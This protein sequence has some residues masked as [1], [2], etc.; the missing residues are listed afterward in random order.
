MGRYASHC[1]SPAL[2]L[3]PPNTL[4]GTH[5][6]RKTKGK[7]KKCNIER[8]WLEQASRTRLPLPAKP[9]ALSL[10]SHCCGALPTLVYI[11][12]LRPESGRGHGGVGCT[13][14]RM[15]CTQQGC[16]LEKPTEGVP[17]R[18]WCR[19]AMW[20]TNVSTRNV[21]EVKRLALEKD[22]CWSS[23]ARTSPRRP[24]EW[25]ENL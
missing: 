12:P 9:S 23:A 14:W 21:K 18:L 16:L 2:L 24:C 1:P 8:T 10:H 13:V 17:G 15:G 19:A 7:G 11:W 22:P 6:L 25:R 3:L 5:V 4:A 20:Y